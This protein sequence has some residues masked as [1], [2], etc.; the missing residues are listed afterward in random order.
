MSS[1]PEATPGRLDWVDTGRGIAIVLVALYHAARWLSRAGFDTDGWQYANTV[2]SSLRM[3]LFFVLSGLFAR[4]WMTAPW[5][6]LLRS[7]LL[8]FI[9]V[10]AI[11]EIIGSAAFVLGTAANGRRVSLW[12]TAVSLL[13]SPL[14]PRLELWFIW[15]LTLF[16]VI[17]KLTR[18]LHYWLQLGVAGVISMVALTVWLN[19]T[20]GLTGSMKYYVFFLIGLHLRSAVLAFGGT[21][22]RLLLFLGLAGWGLISAS[23]VLLQWREIFGLYFLNCLAGVVGGIALSRLVATIPIIASVGR[24]TLPIYLAHTPLIIVTMYVLS[25]TPIPQLMPHAVVVTPLVALAAVGAALA[26]H[27][28]CMRGLLKV[29]YEPPMWLLGVCD[30]GPE[31]APIRR[32]RYQRDRR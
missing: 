12:D 16:F 10:F 1:R 22:R 17:A 30:S 8:L 28:V 18:K 27:R 15:A 32:R 24:Q 23:L 14:F 21:R 25:V 2:M 7:K 29:L 11:W 26:L 6:Q 13:I 19:Q 4:K 5:R 3:P 31:R 20:T 9:W